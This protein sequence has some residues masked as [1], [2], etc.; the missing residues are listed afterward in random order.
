MMKHTCK[1]LDSTTA[2][3]AFQYLEGYYTWRKLSIYRISFYGSG[4]PV[5]SQGAVLGR[6][7]GKPSA[8]ILDVHQRDLVVSVNIPYATPPRSSYKI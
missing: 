4:G 7:A 1:Q 8:L 3:I 2:R 5:V 6:D